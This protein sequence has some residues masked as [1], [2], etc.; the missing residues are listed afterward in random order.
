MS[1]GT[2]YFAFPSFSN[3][4][5]LLPNASP[6]LDRARSLIYS[7]EAILLVA[8]SNKNGEYCSC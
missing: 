1:S 8:T 4:G 6:A 3:T 5:S 7:Q 2:T